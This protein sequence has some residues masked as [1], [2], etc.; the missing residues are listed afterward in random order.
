MVTASDRSAVDFILSPG[1]AHDA[2]QGIFLLKRIQRLQEQNIC[3]WT[4][5]MPAMKSGAKSKN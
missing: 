3:L 1:N 2:P 5:L 4:E